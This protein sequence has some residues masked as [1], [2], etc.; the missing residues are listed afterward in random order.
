VP[1][2]NAPLRECITS[3]EVIV[4]VVEPLID[5][6]GIWPD[7][8]QLPAEAAPEGA[9]AVASSPTALD[10]LLN[11]GFVGRLVVSSQM[12][13]GAIRVFKIP[14]ARALAIQEVALLMLASFVSLPVIFTAKLLVATI[15]G[16]AVRPLMALY[17][18]PRYISAS[19]KAS[20]QSSDETHLSSHGRGNTLE[21]EGHF[22]LTCDGP[23]V[24][25]DSARSLPWV[26]SARACSSRCFGKFLRY[27][28]I[29]G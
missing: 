12:G 19:W 20:F 13:C 14:T 10:V 23:W 5:E 22:A 6:M 25:S 27:S 16:A 15:G 3:H 21:H 9:G 24:H 7:R 1:I 4:N 11:D 8:Y 29:P 2:L 18:L 17:M 28:L 26:L